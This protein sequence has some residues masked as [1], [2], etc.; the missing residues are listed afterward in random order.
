MFATPPNHPQMTGNPARVKQV[1]RI[2]LECL[3]MAA[4]YALPVETLQE[5]CSDL[6]RPPMTFGE[7]GVTEAFLSKNAFIVSIQSAIDPD[8]K[9]WAITDLGKTLLATL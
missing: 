6:L 9:Q 8:L 2:V 7:W 1:R 4:P 5:H 3:K